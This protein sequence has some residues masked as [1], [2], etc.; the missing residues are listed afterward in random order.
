MG[1]ATFTPTPP[2]GFTG[3]GRMGS[4]PIVKPPYGELV[5][6]DLGRGEIAWRVPFGDTPS[7][8]NHPLLQGVKL[9]ERLGASGAPGVIVTKSGLVLGGGGDTA[10]YAFDKATGR[11][12]ARFE[13]P[14]RGNATPMTY[15]AKSGR[16]FIVMAT[17]GGAN[18]ALVA[19]ALNKGNGQSWQR[20]S[21]QRKG[22]RT[23]PQTLD[24]LTACSFTCLCP[25][26]TLPLSVSCLQILDRRVR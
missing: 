23:W 17:G 25:L 12:L 16:Q 3:T 11:E 4:L 1:G 2:P 6:I 19:W 5:A 20:T 15:R 7:V 9:P 13:L 24:A 8:R 26:A 21:E 22:Q 14:R 18:A 10:L